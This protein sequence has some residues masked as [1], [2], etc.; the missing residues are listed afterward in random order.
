MYYNKKN[1]FNVII[2]NLFKFKNFHFI[3]LKFRILTF[4]L[5]ISG[6]RPHDLR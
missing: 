3:Q 1:I 6:P 5:Y 4:Y 2:V